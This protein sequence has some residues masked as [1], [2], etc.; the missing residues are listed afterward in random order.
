[1]HAAAPQ[2]TSTAVSPVLSQ[3]TAAKPGKPPLT[4]AIQQLSSLLYL[5]DRCH[6]WPT[7][8]KTRHTRFRCFACSSPPTLDNA[9]AAFRFSM[10]LLRSPVATP[11][12]FYEQQLSVEAP[13]RALAAI[14]ASRRRVSAPGA[15]RRSRAA[16]LRRASAPDFTGR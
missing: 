2:R 4:G 14:Q 13:A 8:R 9:A 15:S 5:K 1:M 7:C 12:Y 6:F 3:H 10:I 11:D 16:A